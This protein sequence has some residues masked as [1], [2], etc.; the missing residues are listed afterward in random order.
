MTQPDFIQI[1]TQVL[2]DPML[3]PLDK[4]LYGYVYWMHKLKDGTCTANNQTLAELC[5]S[6]SRSISRSLE[7][8]EAAGYIKR[9]YDDETS[10]HRTRIECLVSYG[11]P[12]PVPPD[13]TDV[14]GY[15]QMDVQKKSIKSE[16]I[17]TGANAPGATPPEP[18]EFGNPEINEVV[19]KFQTVMQLTLTRW[20]HQRKAAKTLI[21]RYGLP[22]VLRGI[23]AAAHCRDERFA[24]QI[25]SLEELRDK[26]NNLVEYYRKQQLNGK[27]PEAR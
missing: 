1:P 11:K 20:T 4:V 21:S 2:T 19:E 15:D 22:V 26:W 18:A 7:Q 24:P 27:I 13:Q 10:K 25:L 5:N 12:T 23:E 16:S 8:L 6:A 9:V 17:K 3:Q 14:G